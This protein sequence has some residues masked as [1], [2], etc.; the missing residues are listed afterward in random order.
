MPSTEE[1]HLTVKIVRALYLWEQAVG[2]PRGI[3]G[4][5]TWCHRTLTLSKSDQPINEKGPHLRCRRDHMNRATHGHWGKAWITRPKRQNP[6]HYVTGVCFF[7]SLAPLRAYALEPAARRARVVRLG[8]KPNY[9]L[10][11]LRAHPT[12]SWG[13]PCERTH[14]P[15]NEKGPH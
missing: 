4:S 10:C 8:T 2:V 5:L 12:L 11:L 7:R 15:I 13:T 9:W 14:R 3:G 6:G 1:Y